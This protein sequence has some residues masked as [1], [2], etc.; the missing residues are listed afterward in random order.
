MHCRHLSSYRHIPL[1]L[2]RSSGAVDGA[3]PFWAAGMAEPL[4]LAAIRELR[5][6]VARKIGALQLR[7]S[8]RSLKCSFSNAAAGAAAAAAP[9]AA[10]SLVPLPPPASLC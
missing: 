9:C 6:W 3:T 1:P 10:V 7:Y 2:P 5:W 4:P 8:C